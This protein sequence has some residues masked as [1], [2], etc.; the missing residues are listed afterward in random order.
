MLAFAAFGPPIGAA[1]VLLAFAG[2]ALGAGLAAALAVLASAPLFLVFGY[3]F[4]LGPALIAGVAYAW[5]PRALQR[6][7]LAPL[8]GVAA[9]W[10]FHFVAGRFLDFPAPAESWFVPLAAVVSAPA[11]AFILRRKPTP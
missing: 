8:Y 3:V 2:L 10:L 1:V 5:A 7:V 11:C 9:V 6:I 4:G